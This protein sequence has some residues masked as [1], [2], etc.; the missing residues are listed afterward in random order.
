[1]DNARQIKANPYDVRKDRGASW[2]PMW[3]VKENIK[4][5]NKPKN[6][7]YKAVIM[8]EKELYLRN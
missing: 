3:Y 1:M 5:F 8:N 6:S 2:L 4:F 7:N